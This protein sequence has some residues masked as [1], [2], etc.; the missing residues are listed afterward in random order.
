[1]SK[2]IFSNLYVTYSHFKGIRVFYCVSN[3]H[4]WL[5]TCVSVRRA[6]WQQWWSWSH[7]ACTAPSCALEWQRRDGALFPEMLSPRSALSSSSPL[8][9]NDHNRSHRPNRK[10]LQ[11][12]SERA[13]KNENNRKKINKWK[14][15]GVSQRV[16]MFILF[17]QSISFHFHNEMG[18]VFTKGNDVI[19][20]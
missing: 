13:P 18:C 19:L 2:V 5:H 17:M 15:D 16:F 10:H 4:V 9:Q 6:E 7:A 1:M 14:P 8:K 3:T 12:D 20:L 11:G